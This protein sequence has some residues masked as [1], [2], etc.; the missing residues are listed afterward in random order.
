MA[1]LEDI[2]GIVFIILIF[3]VAGILLLNNYAR[4][5]SDKEQFT[6]QNELGESFES[7]FD[8]ILEITEPKS[9]RSYGELL[10]SATYFRNE[11]L[12]TPRGQVHIEEEFKLLLDLVFPR[13]NYFF[14]VKAPLDRAEI[15]FIVDGSP[16]VE[17]EFSYLADNFDDIASEIADNFDM[18]FSMAV[19]LLDLENS[20]RCDS[21]TNCTYYQEADIYF[22]GTYTVWDLK[23][24]K[25]ELFRP[26]FSDEDD[27]VWRSD[28]ETA[29]MSIL[30]KEQTDNL[31]ELRIFF[32]ITDTLPGA[33]EYFYP[34]PRDYAIQILPRD[35]QLLGK[36]GVI[37]NPILSQNN[38]PV[39]YCDTDVINHMKSLIQ[40]N[41]GVI[42]RNRDNFAERMISVIRENFNTM[43]I[44]VG[45]KRVGRA[46]G[47]ERKLPMP[48][49]EL[50]DA[51]LQIFTEI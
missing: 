26:Y 29:L 35:I 31:R 25:Y 41:N 24:H 3:L 43:I 1:L 12:Y 23:K 51:Q 34:C 19:Y 50:A 22:N 9:M 45:N 15:I 33:T 46:Y 47:L 32:P 27:E 2:M 8:T 48:N 42:I 6:L 4:I 38:D 7:S 21:I 40:F 5:A 18:E 11:K 49:G 44:Q 39:L 13:D 20:T 17:D 30:L 16:T 28:W 10:G 14:E 36:S 37:V